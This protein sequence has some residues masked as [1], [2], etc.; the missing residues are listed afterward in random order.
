MAM[1]LSLITDDVA[2]AKEAERAGVD[3]I[4]IDLEREGKAARQVGRD[5]FQSTHQLES[6]LRV[7]ATL[8]RAALIVRINP[9]SER[10]ADEIAAVLAGGADVIMLPYFFTPGDVRAFLTIVGGRSGVSLLVETKSA[11]EQL[12]ACLACGRVD[13]VHI[14]LNDLSIELGCEVMLEPMSTGV[15]DRLAATLRDAQVP[16]GIGGVARLSAEALPVRPE[17]LLAEQVRLGCTRG[18]LGRTFRDGLRGGRLS[19]EVDR[20]R[21]AVARWSSAPV[22]AHR[23]NRAALFDQIQLWK[24][25]LARERGAESEGRSSSDKTSVRAV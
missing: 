16:F 20:V 4:M 15:I 25:S 8:E 22:E 5:L 17:R 11:A 7:K 14:G 10:T 6:V 24:A 21:E 2:L 23:E 12:A 1:M 9:L 3:R 18:W 19:A 13:E